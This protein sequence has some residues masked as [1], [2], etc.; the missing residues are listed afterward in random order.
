M[1]DEYSL[2]SLFNFLVPDSFACISFHYLCANFIVLEAY[3][4]KK[5]IKEATVL[6][7]E[8]ENIATRDDC[9]MDGE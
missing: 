6:E 4:V 7:Q 1:I 8:K 2:N 5:M 3:F 9:E